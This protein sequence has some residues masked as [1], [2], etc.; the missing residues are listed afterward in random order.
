MLTASRAVLDSVSSSPRRCSSA[1]AQRLLTRTAPLPSGARWFD[2]AG[3]AANS[4]RKSRSPREQVLLTPYPV[5]EYIT[6]ISSQFGLQAIVRPSSAKYIG[7]LGF[8]FILLPPL[9]F[10][11]LAWAL[12]R[13]VGGAMT[14]A[15]RL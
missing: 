10:A 12:R 6:Q 9:L 5:L 14:I 3:S 15:E 1:Q 13:C 7:K 8:L 2:C 4:S 11:K